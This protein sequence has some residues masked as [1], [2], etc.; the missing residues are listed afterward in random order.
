MAIH[1]EFSHRKRYFSIARLNYIRLP[2][3]KWSIF[4]NFPLHAMSVMTPEGHNWPR[5]TS[6]PR[7]DGNDFTVTVAN[8]WPRGALGGPMGKWCS[9]FYGGFCGI[10]WDLRDLVNV[11]IT[12]ENE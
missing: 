7:L 3:S 6:S 2:E 8:Q 11:H 9:R 4:R 12:M 1:S 10:L 5:M